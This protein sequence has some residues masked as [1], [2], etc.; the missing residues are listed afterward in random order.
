MTSV[1]NCTLWV[2]A[3]SAPSSVYASS[4]G[5]S[6]PPSGGSWKKWSITYTE[7]NPDSSDEVARPA[8]WSNKSPGST[9][10]K[11]GN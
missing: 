5:W 10:E 1:P 8:M 4:I 2:R 9:P 11:L 3:A 6:G 7:S